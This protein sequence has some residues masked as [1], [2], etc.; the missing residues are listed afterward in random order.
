MSDSAEVLKEYLISVGVKADTNSLSKFLGI[1]GSIEKMTVTLTTALA[2]GIVAIEGL[3]AVTTNELDDLYWATKRLKS[4]ASDIQDFELR[5]KKAGS[6]AQDARGALETIEAF[7]RTN[8]AGDAFLGLMGI[9]STGK[10]AVQVTDQLIERFKQLK[11][12]GQ[13]WLAFRYGERL[14]LD[15]RMV[16]DMMQATTK[17]GNVFAGMYKRLG[18][19]QEKAMRDAH[20]Y[21]NKLKDLH[22]EFTV[23]S[24]VLGLKFLPVADSFLQWLMKSQAADNI[25]HMLLGLATAL[26]S[27]ADQ[28][29]R[30]G[31]MLPP[32]AAEFGIVGY[33]LFGKKAVI[34]M[35]ALGTLSHVLDKL[36]GDTGSIRQDHVEEAGTSQ[37]ADRKMAR[38][39]YDNGMGYLNSNDFNATYAEFL[40][41]KNH[42]DEKKP[43]VPQ[44]G[45]S[46]KKL[47]LGVRSN[48]PG[49]LMP[50][51]KEAVYNT[52]QEGLK[53]MANQLTRYGRRGLTTLESIIS[54]YAPPGANNTAAYIKRVSREM[55]MSP[56]AQVRLGDPNILNKLMMAMIRVEQGYVPYDS[57]MI[58]DAARAA[59]GAP[60]APAPP[61]PKNERVSQAAPGAQGP[62]GVPGKPGQVVVP[63]QPGKPGVPG[64]PGTP[65]KHTYAG[66]GVN[67]QAPT[68]QAAP[69]G[70]APSTKN[71]TISQT[72]TTTIHGAKDPEA[73]AKK[74]ERVS[75]RNNGDLVRNFSTAVI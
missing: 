46:G 24:Q 57:G 62:A 44:V 19:N 67:E 36:S 58:A 31:A 10:G 54:T 59:T 64:Q 47:P 28:A 9:N 25:G 55:S 34:I 66:M 65:S 5:M 52:P 39:F 41:R 56:T 21:Q 32:E 11:A 74:V 61:V 16:S 4:S 63:G 26:A 60:P 75:S 73:T 69:I 71:V 12:Q 30:F 48:N 40:N 49:N 17:S 38:W 13:E 8:P 35:A 22:A 43:V 72:N 14:G 29:A 68:M 23:A 37:R 45:E 6:S 20:E 33:A 3:V 50:G 51:G 2:A 53:A 27:V 7:R 42:P 15:Y 18:L 1:I 70:A